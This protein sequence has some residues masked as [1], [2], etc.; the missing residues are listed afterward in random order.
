MDTT[1]TQLRVSPSKP[2]HTRTTS[3][4]LKSIMSK[5]HQRKP[6]PKEAYLGRNDDHEYR[7]Q[8]TFPHNPMPP[9]DHPNSRQ[10]LREDSGN[11]NPPPTSQRKSVDVQKENSRVS[12]EIKRMTR[13]T[14]FKALMDKEKARGSKQNSEKGQ[15]KPMKKSKSSTSLSA[16]LSRPRS[17]TKAAREETLRRQNEK[18]NETPKKSL[19]TAPPPIWAQFATQAFQ[20]PSGTTKVPLNDRFDIHEEVA[21]YTPRD[22]SPSKQRNFQGSEQPTLSRRREPKPRPKSECLTS[23]PTPASFAETV[24]NLRRSSR[25]K[26]Q[27]NR[28]QLAQQASQ[29]LPITRESLPDN[30]TS[31]RRPSVDHCRVSDG[32]S[33]SDPVMVKGG[34]RVMAAVAAFNGKS[35]ELPKEPTQGPLIPELG[36][37]AIEAAFESLLV[38]WLD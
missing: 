17:S 33:S 22:Y 24:A 15:G 13:S 4:V 7:N 8:H 26:G 1:T 5:P 3:S 11:R 36:T 6:P 16:L 32:S 27:V 18:E 37:N 2:Q 35:K 14:S 25:D 34:S 38:S 28:S 23:E 9:P 20:E 29:Y 31:S 10:H 19:D 30:K 12:E 21:L